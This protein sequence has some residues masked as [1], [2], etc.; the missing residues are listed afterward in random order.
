MS[1]TYDDGLVEVFSVENVAEK[2]DMPKDRLSLKASYYFGYET[3]GL[4]RYYAAKSVDIA[5]DEVIHIY[6]DRTI[7]TN[8]IAVVNG[9]S[10]TI[11]QVQHKKDDDGINITVLSLER[12]VV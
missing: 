11:K 10:Y 3:V 6:E 7:T 8:D 5:I 4:T 1:Y 12:Q 9:I 2:G